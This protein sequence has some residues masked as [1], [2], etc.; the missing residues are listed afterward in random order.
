MPASGENKVIDII[1]N[2]QVSGNLTTDQ[3]ARKKSIK[4]L[5][6]AAGLLPG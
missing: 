6:Q 5:M 2:R 4:F 3:S 1:L